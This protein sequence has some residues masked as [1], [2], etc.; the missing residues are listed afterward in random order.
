MHETFYSLAAEGFLF[1]CFWYSTQVLFA[2]FFAVLV[3][4]CSISVLFYV[5]LIILQSKHN[6]QEYDRYF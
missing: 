4:C 3:L 5:I 2:T 6:L 1:V